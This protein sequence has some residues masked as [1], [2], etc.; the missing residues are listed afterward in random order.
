VNGSVGFS[1]AGEVSPAGVVLVGCVVFSGVLFSSFDGEVPVVGV[2]VLD[3]GVLDVGVLDVGV[4]VVGGVV[5]GVVVVGGGGVWPYPVVVVLARA[6]VVIM[7]ATASD[8]ATG[9]TRSL[10]I[11]LGS[12]FLIDAAPA[13][14]G[15]L[16]ATISVRVMP[17]S[18]MV[19]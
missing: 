8:T 6:G 11:T 10:R 18:V 16:E 1:F 14:C 13:A 4:L 17:T 5:A 19:W 12:P 15:L 2:G 3:V 7:S 9:R